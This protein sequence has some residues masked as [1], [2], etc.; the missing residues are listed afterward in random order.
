MA[1]KN[2]INR[3]DFLSTMSAAG[4][5]IPLLNLFP[6]NL[7]AEEKKNRP[8]ICIF[9]KHLQFLPDF[10]SMAEVA[11]EIGF[12][13]VDLT[14]RPGGHV[15]PENVENDLPLAATA[16]NK[17]GLK[18]PMMVTGIT[19]ADEPY[20]ELTLKIAHELGIKFYRMGYFS[21]DEK[22]GVQRSLEQIKT[23]I[24]GLIELNKKYRINGAYQNH[25][26]D[27]VGAP[28]WD[29]WWLLKEFDPQWIGSQY[30]IR[31][32]SVEGAYSWPLAMELL[33][34]YIK[35]TAIKDFFWIKEK[36][37]WKI[38]NCPLGDGMVDFSTYFQLYKQAGIS[39][40]ISLHIEYDVYTDNDT[41]DAKQ[42]KTILAMKKDLETL[43]RWLGKYD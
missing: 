3:R 2:L 25:S 7:T 34:P 5:S 33:R 1:K 4:I 22:I 32:A 17:A 28:V 35:T 15:L 14:V 16:I 26:G 41:L 42:K 37:K 19:G 31:H 39:G 40:P 43:R 27:G 8:D 12:D 36:N 11:A 21:Y 23:K 38:H 10:A 9:S 20:A 18:V 29:L 6:A 30:D 13:G 24:A